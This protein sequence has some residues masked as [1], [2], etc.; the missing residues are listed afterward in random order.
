MNLASSTSSTSPIP[1]DEVRTPPSRVVF[2]DVDG[3]L[4]PLGP[5]HLPLHA[6]LE[7]LS[8]RAD[9]ELAAAVNP[10]TSTST[11]TSPQITRVVSGE[12]LP[13]CLQHLCEIL[14]TT[15]ASIILSS[16]WRETVAGQ[17]AVN[18]E[19]ENAGIP[20]F[21]GWTPILG[22]GY[23]HRGEEIRIWLNNNPNVTQYI[24]LDD[25]PL[26]N[27]PDKDRFIQVDMSKGLTTPDVQKAIELFN[28]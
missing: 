17:N 16:T 1:D 13:E 12:F 27:L 28:K 19:L 24:V 21:V 6:D 22:C 9:E 18:Q 4:H 20:N 7:D 14:E 25:Q 5:N 8:A 10:D 2:L 11:S 26:T 3:V 15:H 23:G